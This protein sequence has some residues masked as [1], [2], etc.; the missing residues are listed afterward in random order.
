MQL[1]TLVILIYFSTCALLTNTVKYRICPVCYIIHLLDNGRCNG[2]PR[3]V[4]IVTS[5]VHKT[6]LLRQ[7]I[8]N[9]SL[10]VIQFRSFSS[11]NLS[12]T[13]STSLQQRHLILLDM[14]IHFVQLHQSILPSRLVKLACS[15]VSVSDSLVSSL[16]SL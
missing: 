4:F 6:S 16:L 13:A 11:V 8:L 10:F 5:A 7:T 14:G 1:L 15:L 12:S 9:C 3:T 2:S